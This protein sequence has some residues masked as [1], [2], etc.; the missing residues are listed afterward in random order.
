MTRLL[1][2][3]FLTSP[4]L[5]ADCVVTMTA[6]RSH[7]TAGHYLVAVNDMDGDGQLDLLLLTGDVP[8]HVA[9]QYGR[10]GAPGRERVSFPAF[11]AGTTGDFD[12]DGRPDLLLSRMND[13]L[14]L[15]RNLGG[16][17]YGPPES[18]G[19]VESWTTPLLGDFDRDGDLD[20]FVKPWNQLPRVLLNDGQGRFTSAEPLEKREG[21]NITEA[22][23]VVDITGDGILDL[24]HGADNGIVLVFQGR[25]DGSF[26]RQETAW[27][28][29][30]TLGFADLN[31][32]GRTDLIGLRAWGWIDVL[33]GPASARITN[34]AA[35]RLPAQYPVNLA[36]GDFN[37]DGATDVAV[38][39]GRG[40][41]ANRVRRSRWRA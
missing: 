33:F 39:N 18:L 4:L 41:A 35:Y 15:L 6:A 9:I 29:G 3:L 25:G 8:R 13:E 37:G 32:D 31:G 12:A 20:F 22:T 19:G 14:L 21:F 2:L 30:A 10:A 11:D 34:T 26:A 5:A 23:H 17:R 38:V 1:L 16:R 36:S 40:F 24:A 27:F 28:D 7:A